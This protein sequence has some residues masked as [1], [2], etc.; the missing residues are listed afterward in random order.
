MSHHL[1]RLKSAARPIS[2]LLVAC[3]LTVVAAAPPA[4]AVSD[5]LTG[6][7]NWTV[8]AGVT[9]ITVE[10]W[11]GGGGGGADSSST[12][13]AGG[14]GGGGAYAK[15]N[16]Y[17]V[18]PGS[19]IAYSVGG[20]G[21]SGANGGDTSFGT[22]GTICKADGGNA[23][24]NAGFL[25]NGSSGSGGTIANSTG[26]V[27]IAGGAGAGGQ[28]STGG[29]G[30]GSAGTAS[31]GN[32]TANSTGAT[33]VSGGGAGGNGRSN[34]NGDAAPAPGPG[35]GGGG[36]EH[37]GGG[38]GNRTGGAGYAGKLV[39]TY[40]QTPSLS[41]TNS[42][43]TY[44]GAP[45]AVALAAA[46]GV[47]P[48][49]GSFSNVQYNGSGTVPTNAGSYAITADFTPDNTTNY[50]SL[51][52]VAVGSFVIQPAATTT[53]VTCTAGPFTYDG[54]AKT[55][56]AATVTG[57]N[58][59]SENVAVTYANN[60][61]AGTAS[62]SAT[63]AGSTNYNTSTGSATFTIAKA[64]T[65]TTVTCSGGPFTYDGTAKTPC[66]A[67]VTGPNGLSENV[68]VTY[69][70]NVNA[71]TA[72]ASA[73]YAGS[74]NY[75]TSTGGATFT[76][77]KAASTTTVTCG[78]GTFPYTGSPVEPCS[79]AATGAG[80]LNDPLT[81]VYA[82]NTNTGTASASA[83]F[84][85]DTNHLASNG[86]TTFTISK[87]TPVLSVSGSP[88]TYDGAQHAA[89]VSGLPGG[90][91][92][93]IKYDGSAT[94]PTNAG[95]YAV[96]ADFAPT[97]TNY[98]SLTNAP[99]GSFVI[100]PAATTTTVTCTPGPFT[101]DGTAKTPCSAIVT[102]PN[103]LNQAVTVVYANNTGAGTATASATYAGSTNY[104]TST[105]SATFTIDKATPTL[106]ILNSP[107]TYDAG[108]KQAEVKGSV[109]G[110]VSNVKYDGTATEPAGAGSYLVTADFTPTDTANY[111]TL[112]NESAGSFVI[113]KATPTLSIDNSPVTYD[114]TAKQ[115]HVKGSVSGTAANVTY[116]GSPALPIDTGTYA[117]VADFTPDDTA[118]Y[119]TLSGASAGNFVI[120]QAGTPTLS[121]TNSPLTYNGAA[122][123]AIV[124]GSV[125]GNV[126][127]IRYNGSAAV[128]AGAG[129]YVITADFT[130]TDSNY[131][132][133]TAAIAGT[134]VI[135][136][137]G[138]T[139]TVTCGAGPFTYDGTAKTPCT[140]TVTGPAGLNQALT[141]VYANNI[142]AGTASASANYAGGSNYLSSSNAKTFTIGKATPSLA[143]TNS[144]VTY[145]GTPKAAA[146]AGSVA[147]TVSNV[148]YNGSATAPTNAGTYAVTA[149]F[150][151]SDTTN[152]NARSSAPAGNFAILKAGT[153]ALVVS[154][155]P[156][157]YDGA[158]K[159]AN[160]GSSVAGTV[161]NVRYDGSATA[162]TN[163]GTYAITVDFTPN[164][165]AN[166]DSL[167]GVSAGSFTI[168]KATTAVVVSC[169]AGPFTYS[170]A[171]ITPCTASVT[172]PNGLSQALTV[173]YADNT[174][175][176]T[177][178][179][180]ASYAGSANYLPSS[181]AA[182][183]TIDKAQTTTTVTCTV[184]P[185]PATGA[186]IEPCSASVSGPGGLSGDLAVTYADNVE[187][188][189]ATASASYG[190]GANYLPSSDTEVF[191]IGEAVDV[192]T[193]L[194]LPFMSK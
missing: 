165:T 94:E 138:T 141:V 16:N 73:T 21:G 109:N 181:A 162:P 194:H 41:I 68:A 60:T 102:G 176:G 101:Y 52:N 135:Q 87:G 69:A 143:V 178:A 10:C 30:G 83:S 12:D 45:H 174:D 6:S 50:N 34:N 1:R 39:I 158:P 193:Y 145:D 147:G 66:T 155:S 72:S 113:N 120:Q 15:R 160:V 171:A 133:L 159:A 164:D 173:S 190:G 99:A 64:A 134:L 43:V 22:G 23:G 187:P 28:T 85:G 11:G 124:V 90:T 184:G 172:G 91:A 76:I 105:G 54:T 153:P 188:G 163:A 100:Q 112:T 9:S 150:T 79:A 88:V 18:T 189:A 167:T 59:L 106:S 5:T 19:P 20:G 95:T 42:P 27:R 48:V 84:G 82:D 32:S 86:S 38:S 104:L 89:T 121:V 152:Y 140:A 137:A 97:D 144:P 35:G 8:P 179:A 192:T 13:G 127:N 25:S 67:T 75:N 103:N 129:S 44:D 108:A 65:T 37:A 7:G 17:S 96:T 117:V 26:D 131:N 80:G 57:P 58:G 156:E 177:A 149:D 142:N 107:V 55:P 63:Y 123:Q 111:K 77:D 31:T 53:T 74:T 125:A 168:A 115:A 151:P 46:V 170:G 122:Q 161:S 119:N 61:G 183:F 71:G 139:T 166:Y 180:N 93:N 185:F 175:A 36:G 148:R 92:S 98:N 186:P 47:T 40:K 81:V 51:T 70:D 146:V 78:A 132:S 24:G 62:A 128:P 136:K 3:L 33:A 157:T 126:T 29:G 49:T 130:P 114:G 118:N 116:N 182:S 14:G 4:L 56:C 110:T 2:A 169:G 154:N 191:V